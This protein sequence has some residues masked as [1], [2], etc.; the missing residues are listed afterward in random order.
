[1]TSGVTRHFDSI[2]AEYDY[3]KGKNWYYYDGLKRLLRSKIPVSASVAEIGC[4]TG[5]LLA[6]LDP[7]RGL[8]IDI[9]PE[10]ISIA[11]KK[12]RAK[13]HIEFLAADIADISLPLEFESVFMVDVLEHLE[14]IDGFFGHLQRLMKPGSSLLITIA[15]PF[16]EPVLLVAEKLGLKMPE[17]P[18]ERLPLTATE[19]V[20]QRHGFCIKEKGSDLLCPVPIPLG[21][22]F[23]RIP[24]YIPF[25][26]HLE[27]I[28]FWVLMKK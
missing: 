4:G 17:G 5:N 13:T 15:N 28:R 9:S 8:G 24:S 26:K 21:N 23:N 1:M 10:M 14:D 16:W 6:S 12:H 3:W 2:A 18:H 20:F 27:F 22:W 11:R 7:L 25:L 19:A